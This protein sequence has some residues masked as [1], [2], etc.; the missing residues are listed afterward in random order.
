MSGGTTTTKTQASYDPT[1][2]A[3]PAYDGNPDFPDL[4]G[5]T[6]PQVIAIGQM[7][8]ANIMAPIHRR[9]F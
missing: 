8:Q 5:C 3:L 1:L 2:Q 7:A 6:T 9:T 4:F